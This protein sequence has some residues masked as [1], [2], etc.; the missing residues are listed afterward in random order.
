MGFEA[1][2]CGTSI[3]SGRAL[4]T[5]PPEPRGPSY[6]R[7]TEMN[8][9]FWPRGVGRPGSQPGRYPTWL[10]DG[11][12]FVSSH[13]MDDTLSSGSRIRGLGFSPSW[14]VWRGVNQHKGSFMIVFLC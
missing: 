10:S 12:Y 5:D 8:A 9:I 14:R 13:S 7:S 4:F 1:G 2:C 11:A 3:L 6:F